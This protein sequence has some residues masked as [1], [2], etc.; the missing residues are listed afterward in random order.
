MEGHHG[1]STTEKAL[2]EAQ[3]ERFNG[4]EIG[5]KDFGIKGGPQYLYLNYAIMLLALILCLQFRG[6][7]TEDYCMQ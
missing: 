6:D 5:R 1:R 3:L 2:K 7:C 4:F